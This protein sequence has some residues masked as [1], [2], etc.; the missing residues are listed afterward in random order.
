M[1]R[2][3]AKKPEE[4]VGRTGAG[5]GSIGKA[6]N[7]TLARRLVRGVT[8][9]GRGDFMDRHGGPGGPAAALDD[10]PA[11]MRNFRH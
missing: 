2:R 3:L 8:L 1:E 7:F 6:T 10:S 9:S 11:A 5:A 4:S